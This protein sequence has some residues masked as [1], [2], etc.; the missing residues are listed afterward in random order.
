MCVQ[1][2]RLQNNFIVTVQAIA[3]GNH[4]AGCHGDKFFHTGFHNIGRN[5]VSSVLSRTRLAKRM[6]FT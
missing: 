2:P 4:L 6:T 1:L 3:R 5:L